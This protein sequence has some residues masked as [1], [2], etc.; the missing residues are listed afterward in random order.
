M[1][2][3]IDLF[4]GCGGLSLGLAKSGWTGRF[5]V[6]KHPDAFKTLEANLLQGAHKNF[7]WPKWLEKKAWSIQELLSKHKDEIASLKGSIDLIAGGPPCQGYSTAGRRNPHDGRN[8]LVKQYLQFVKLVQPRFLLLENVMGFTAGFKAFTIDGKVFRSKAASVELTESLEKLGYA[9]SAKLI[10]CA[11]WGVPQRRLRF[12]ALAVRRSDFSNSSSPNLMEFLEQRRAEFLISR[13]LPSDRHITTEEALYDLQTSA[14]RLEVDPEH[15]GFQRLKYVEEPS[16][17]SYVQAMRAGA[18]GDA[19]NS[20]R[21]PNHRKD[22]VLRFTQILQSSVQGKNLSPED[23][24]K[25]G[26]KKHTFTPLSPQKPSSTVTTLP[27]DMLHFRE[28]RILTVR[29]MARLQSFPDWYQFH[30]KYTTG[31]ANRASDCPRYTQVGN[32]VPPLIGEAIGEALL[33]MAKTEGPKK[34]KLKESVRA[35]K[36]LLTSSRKLR[37]RDYANQ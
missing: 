26:L 28:P 8:Q 22:T 25:F 7:E 19:P 24:I 2:K 12:I 23:R 5:A 35:A 30:G 4:A 20:M 1:P 18:G 14:D 29:E 31:G 9:V 27:D 34:V 36:N 16:Y 17:S 11:D 10:N 13:E 15:P 33:A 6:E 32:A 37:A 21:L 3:F